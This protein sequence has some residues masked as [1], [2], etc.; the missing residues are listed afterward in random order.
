MKKLALLLI[1]LFAQLNFLVSQTLSPSVIATAG[2]F[3]SGGG[4]TLSWTMGETFYTT[5]QNGNVVLTQG[6]QQPFVEIRILNMSL[7]LQGFYQGSGLMSN[8]LNVTGVS[9]DPLDADSVTISVM[10]ASAPYNLI[11]SKIGIL[12]TNGDVT[13]SYSSAVLVN[14][15]YYLRVTHRNSVETWSK[16][17]VLL[18]SS[19]TYS[20]KTAA[21][22]AFGDNQALT[23]D[24]LYFAMYSGDIN[25]DGAVDGGDFLELDPSI[26]NGD[27][28][29]AIGDLNGD[30]AVDGGDFLVIDPNILQ[31]V[32]AAI[33]F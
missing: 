24:N 8:C 1:V 33:P 15:S 10:Q 19:S 4:S 26:Q 29:Y 11:E 30:G 21:S 20:F 22:Q 32:G 3:F 17:P 7:F 28:G 6:Q 23:F 9:P 5:L 18:T 13:V 14:T 16:F 25:H 12:K 2:G 31:G 27:G